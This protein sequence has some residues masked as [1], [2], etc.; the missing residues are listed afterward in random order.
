MCCQSDDGDASVWL[1]SRGHRS[2]KRLACDAITDEKLVGALVCPAFCS[3]LFLPSRSQRTVVTG[4]EG[5]VLG[6]HAKKGTKT[7]WS[8]HPHSV[9]HPKKKLLNLLHSSLL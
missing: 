2:S 3:V 8:L 6:L 7:P 5:L 9:M 4:R 1:S